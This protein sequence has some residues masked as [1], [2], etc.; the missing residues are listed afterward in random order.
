MKVKYLTETAW[1]LQTKTGCYD[2]ILIKTPVDDQWS[3]LTA[4]HEQKFVNFGQVTKQFGKLNLEKPNT[5]ETINEV[6]G[7]PVKHS[8]VITVENTSLPIYSKGGDTKYVAG[9]FGIKYIKWAPSFCPK[10]S[11]LEQY[12]YIGPFKTRL[13]ML[14][15]INLKN[16]GE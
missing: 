15:E 5:E 11:T 14:N 16:K 12:E 1:L 2:G 8:V 4:E 7:F 9:Y 3:F 6:N 10:L 13:E